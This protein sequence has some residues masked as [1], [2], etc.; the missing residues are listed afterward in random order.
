MAPMSPRPP[1]RRSDGRSPRVLLDGI[2]FGESV[3]WHEHRAWLC[4]WGTGDIL[5]VDLAGR[6]EV[7]ARVPTVPTSID[8]LPDGSLLVLSR[9]L[10]RQTAAG[11]FVTHAELA[12]LALAWNE[13]VV[14]GRGNAFVNEVGFDL[15]AGEEPRP[16]SIAVVTP[17]GSARRVADDLWFPNGMAVTPDDSTLVVAESYRGRL[18]AYDIAADG[19]LSG[20]RVWADLKVAAPDGICLDASGA[21]WYADVPHRRCVRVAE[22][23]EVLDLV[24]SDR[25]CFSCALGG[26]A[27]RT[28]FVVGQEW[29]GTTGMGVGPRTGQVVMVEVDEP[30]AGR[31]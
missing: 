21:V 30:H 10:E 13:L 18:T 4:D 1:G 3:R 17:D 8:W 22:G 11:T 27:G 7:V 9:R 2:S 6:A 19:T 14:D 23:G 12:D 5:A 28:L 15:M 16:G 29:R 20:R 25:G 26:T 24:E 31:P